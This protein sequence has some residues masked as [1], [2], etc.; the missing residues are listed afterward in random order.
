MTEDDQ[1]VPAATVN[2]SS[3]VTATTDGEG[4]YQLDVYQ[5]A[6]WAGN[7]GWVTHPLYEDTR[8][9]VPWAP[10]QADVTQNCRLYR[11]M[12]LV[13]GEAARL[14]ISPNNSVCTNDDA[15]FLYRM[16]HVTM[17]SSGTLL[18][19]TIADD[20]SNTF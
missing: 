7:W 8:K 9:I 6:L 11:S 20:P 13:A 18:L 17:P 14:A 10:G 12:T 3:P 19:D 16:V 4:V 1:P 5:L 2:I 15:E